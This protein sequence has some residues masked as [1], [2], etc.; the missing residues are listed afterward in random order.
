MRFLELEVRNLRAIERFFVSDLTDF[1]MIAG[2]NGCGKSCVF[3]G[4]RLLKSLYGGYQADEHMQWFGEFAVNVQ[5]R[6]AM[7]QL[8]RN[9]AEPMLIRAEMAFAPSE[10][11]YLLD[12]ISDLAWPLAWQRVTGQRMDPWSFNRMAVA[13]VLQQYRAQ[14]EVQLASIKQDVEAALSHDTITLAAEIETDGM[15]RLSDCRPAEVAFQSYRPENLG[16]I[17]YHSASRTYSR[18]QVGG[19]T[20]DTRQFA[21]QRRQQTLYNSQGK[22][23]NVKTELAS[24]YVHNLIEAAGGTEDPNREDLNETLKQLFQTFFPDKEYLGVRPVAGGGLEFPVR[25]PNGHTHDIDDLSSGEKEILYGYLRLRN[26]TPKHSIVLL[27]E[28]ELHLNPSLLQGFTDFYH[29][30][31]GRAQG[32]Q[33]WLVTHSD[34][35]LR[36]TVGNG[37]Y[38]VYHMVSSSASTGGLENQAAEVVLDD[39]VERAAIDLVGDLASYR[40]HAKVVILEGESPSEFD[41]NMVR[42]LFPDVA[43]R[44]NL[45]SG[46][47]KR[48]VRD[49]YRVLAEAVEKTGITNRFFAIVDRDSGPSPTQESGAQEFAWDVYHIENYL[50]D[51]E[52][53]RLAVVSLTGREVFSSHEDVSVALKECARLIVDRLVLEQVQTAIND[54]F[55]RE[56][57]IGAPRD[58]TSIAHALQPSIRASV[59]RL[60]TL[61]ARLDVDEIE[62]R[63]AEIT[64]DLNVSLEDGTWWSRFPGRLILHRFAEIHV[65]GVKYEALANVILDKMVEHDVQPSGMSDVLERILTA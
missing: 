22:Y 36:Q 23:Q 27:D 8:F 42:R 30:H 63:V 56:L 34:T 35:L 55:R 48:R 9:P 45:V 60:T 11:K 7:Q 37:N 52:S 19:I 2:P 12:N 32:N 46:G 57:N 6:Q 17:E 62:A 10:K 54:E 39:D 29:D 51:A 50:L 25:L 44:V 18:Q 21:D 53:I 43:K 20:L 65:N 41:V 28:P 4:I 59:E 38:R 49:L 15:L 58:A 64:R 24:A 47:P 16:I 61:A 14:L 13:S 33:L 3:D 40:P 26:A 31:L 5:D 1:I